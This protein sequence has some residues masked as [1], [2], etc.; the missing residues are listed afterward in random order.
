[1][2]EDRIKISLLCFVVAMG[3]MSSNE[4]ATAQTFPSKP[5]QVI[6]NSGAGSAPDTIL[7]VIA[8][9]LA[10]FWGQQVVVM[11]RPGAVGSLAARAAATAPPDGYTLYFAVSSSFVT[12]KGQAPNVPI[13]LPK[14]FATISLIGET[15]FVMASSPQVG[16]KTVAGLIEVARRKPGEISYA[17]AGRGRQSHLIAEMLQRRTGTKLLMVPYSGG[18]AQAMSD[19]ASGRVQLLIEGGIALM[20]SVQAGKLQGLAVLSDAR[21]AEFPDLPTAAETIPGFR[22][23]GWLAMLAPPGTPE[24]IVRRVNED[25]RTVLTRPEV[26][27]RL[28]TL[29]HYVRPMS[30]QDTIRY[31]QDEQATWKPILDEM[32][33]S[34]Q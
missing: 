11:N 24:L 33:A 28:T 21:L 25:L 32:P 6:S 20:G 29:G 27:K 5:L 23:V 17:S 16:F 30:P 10:Q 2:I 12:M 9:Q 8:D 3:S 19:L 14:D 18:P 4:R 22:S 31:I 13:E 1:M 7:R 15:P 34:G 26:R